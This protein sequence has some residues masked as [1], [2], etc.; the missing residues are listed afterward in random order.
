MH[1]IAPQM[2]DEL[3]TN[4]VST[5]LRYCNSLRTYQHCLATIDQFAKKTHNVES[6]L[7]I[8][9]G[10]R[11]IQKQQC[12]LSNKLNAQGHAFALFNAKSS[13]RHCELLVS[14]SSEIETKQTYLR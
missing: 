7:P 2:V 1:R 4:Q 6:T 5:T 8:K 12:R 11:F 13:S 10:S 9:T 14:L 3:Y